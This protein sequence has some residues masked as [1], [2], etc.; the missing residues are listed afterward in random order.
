MRPSPTAGQPV[1]SR[2]W[3]VAV[4]T[5]FGTFMALS[6]QIRGVG[7]LVGRGASP[8]AVAGTTQTLQGI[9]TLVLIAS[10]RPLRVGAKRMVDGVRA[11]GVPLWTF[12][13]GIFG[14]VQ[15]AVAGLVSPL[16]GIAALTVLLVSGQTANGLIVDRVGLTP[17]GPRPIS[18]TRV[19]G[20]LLAV[21]AVGLVWFGASGSDVGS[22]PWWAV[23]VALVAGAGAA[24]QAALNGRV[25]QVSGQPVVAAEVNFV[26]GAAVMWLAVGLL[27]LVGSG[28][29]PIPGWDSAWLYATTIFGLLLI[30]NISWA[31][32]HLGVLVLS[33][34]GVVGQISGAILVDLVLPLPGSGFEAALVL[35][36][37]VSMV[38]VVVATLGR[39][40]EA[41]RGGLSRRP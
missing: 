14:S 39:G 27:A 17:G 41:A 22:A 37:I 13:A 28:Q 8:L 38:A 6:L 15:I 18:M 36:L 20:A 34:V 32:K 1:R 24:I 23:V 25:A 7:E 26:V 4:A 10:V 31:V 30:V 35:S 19:V 16:I 11:R 21:A 33:L 29:S 9:V 3:G 12:T 40:R 5:T 2:A